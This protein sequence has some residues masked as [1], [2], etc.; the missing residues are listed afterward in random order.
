MHTVFF[1]TVIDNLLNN[2][3]EQTNHLREELKLR[4]DQLKWILNCIVN[5]LIYS[6]YRDEEMIA[7]MTEFSST[8]EISSREFS[9]VSTP[10]S[11]SQLRDQN[12]ITYRSISRTFAPPPTSRYSYPYHDF[13]HSEQY[14][15][16]NI[17]RHSTHLPPVLP[18]SF[19][20]SSSSSASSRLH[21]DMLSNQKIRTYLLSTKGSN[22]F[23]SMQQ[24]LEQALVTSMF[25][26]ALQ[27]KVSSFFVV[28]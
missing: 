19:T 2:L 11:T 14:P 26:T 7:L 1:F 12:E 25:T 18:S 27:I 22:S 24:S 6:A 3:S 10:P 13:V 16:S 28:V 5:V 4:Y 20:S 15:S 23:L 21:N 8:Y 9:R 17:L